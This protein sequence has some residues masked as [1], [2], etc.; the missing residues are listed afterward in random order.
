M[1][2]HMVL[3]QFLEQYNEVP[4]VIEVCPGSETSFSFSIRKSRPSE[5]KYAIRFLNSMGAYE[6]L[7]VTGQAKLSIHLRWPKIACIISLPVWDSTKNDAKEY[8]PGR[9]YR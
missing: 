6:V 8:S 7:E 2:I 1:D 4:S 3:D 9:Y 5:E